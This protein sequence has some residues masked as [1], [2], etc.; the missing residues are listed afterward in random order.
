MSEKS[1]WIG[2]NLVKGIGSVRLKALLEFFGDARTAWDAT[3]ADLR[4]AGLSK[5]IVERFV[6]VRNNVD[7]AALWDDI[8]AKNIW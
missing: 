6:E 3:P 8:A 2:I 7:L 4:A 5:K 1:Y